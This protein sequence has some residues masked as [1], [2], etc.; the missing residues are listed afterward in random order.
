M[1]VADE[2]CEV[3]SE[4]LTVYWILFAVGVVLAVVT[5]LFG[6][7]FDFGADH[8]PFLSPTVLASFLTVFGGTGAFLSISGNLPPLITAAISIVVALTLTSV[9]LFAVIL[10]LHRAQQSAAFSSKEM[11][12]KMAEVITPIEPG[13]R[14]EIIYEQGGSRLSAPAKTLQ[15]VRIEQGESVWIMDVVSGTFI[16]EKS[17]RG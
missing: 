12:G 8:L 6:D 15:D 13:K 9:I 3:I 2:E 14:G 17:G 7:I 5:I 1:E 11:I 10:P 16:V 4:M